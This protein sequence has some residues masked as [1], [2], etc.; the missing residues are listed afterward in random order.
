V[1]ALGVDTVYPDLE[2]DQHAGTVHRLMVLVDG[3]R[4]G[5]C[6]A[7]EPLPWQGARDFLAAECSTHGGPLAPW[8]SDQAHQA[9]S[10]AQLVG[11]NQPGEH[12]A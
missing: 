12:T 1:R 5:L 7:H 8:I 4:A 11:H 10:H 9:M 3:L 6:R 2:A